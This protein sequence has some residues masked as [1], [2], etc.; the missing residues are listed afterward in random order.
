MKGIRSALI[1][2]RLHVALG[3]PYLQFTG[4]DRESP[5]RVDCAIRAPW[6]EAGGPRGRLRRGREHGL[7]G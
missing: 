3:T 7:Q 2:L 1:P 5:V 6:H 4:A